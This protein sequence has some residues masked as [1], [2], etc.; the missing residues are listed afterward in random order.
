MIIRDKKKKKKR[1]GWQVRRDAA[2]VDDRPAAGFD[3]VPAEDLAGLEHG[4]AG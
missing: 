1:K 4:L 3:H 2:D